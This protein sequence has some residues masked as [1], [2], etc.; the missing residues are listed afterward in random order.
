[1]VEGF[2]SGGKPSTKAAIATLRKVTEAKRVL[3]VLADEDELNWLSL[4]N[5]PTVHLLEAGQL[6]TYD[7]LVNDT[8]VFTTG[9]LRA[10]CGTPAEPA[11]EGE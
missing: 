7:V 9:A 3:V 4:R 11:E 1:V 2:V 6:N 10:F 5:E 8:V